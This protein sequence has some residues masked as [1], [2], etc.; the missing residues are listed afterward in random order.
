LGLP[1][2]IRVGHFAALLPEGG[3]L[4]SFG[5]GGDHAWCVSGD[6]QPIDLSIGFVYYPEYPQLDSAVVG[7][8]KNGPFSV[9]NLPDAERLQNFIETPRQF[10]RLCYLEKQF[11]QSDEDTLLNHPETFFFASDENG[12][13][14]RY[15]ADIFSKITLH[16]YKV[17]RGHAKPLHNRMDSRN[18][19]HHIRTRYS[20]AIP[21]LRQLLLPVANA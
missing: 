3:G 17:V 10:P 15:G 4:T 11:R 5:T 7:S 20:A 18:A 19:F 6:T 8:G 21:K 9:E 13:L 2:A 12:W 14:T 16:I 1:A